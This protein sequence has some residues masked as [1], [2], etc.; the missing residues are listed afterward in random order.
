MNKEPRQSKARAVLGA[1][2]WRIPKDDWASP[3]SFENE[4][5][6]PPEDSSASLKDFKPEATSVV[7]AKHR[8]DSSSDAGLVPQ[9]T[10][11]GV[12]LHFEKD[13]PKEVIP[14]RPAAIPLPQAKTNKPSVEEDPFQL[15][16]DLPPK[17]RLPEPLKERSELPETKVATVTPLT[18]HRRQRLPRRSSDF[19]WNSLISLALGTLGL[20]LLAW[21][22]LHD[23]PRD[24]DEDLRPQVSVDQ[25]PTTQAPVKLRAFLNSVLPVEDISLRAQAPWTWE[26][27]A[28]SSFVRAN[29][30][31][32]DNLRDLL[33]DY[34][35]H[36][37]H[38]SWYL[39]DASNH[40][41]WRHA[42]CLLQAQA[43]YLARRGDEEPAFV[44]AIDL[45]EM[46]RRL[47]EVWAWSGYMQRAL[48]LQTAS[49]QILGELLKSTHL[50]SA[51][52]GRFQEEFIQC[53][54][55]DDL[56]RQA[57]AA[58][59]IHEKK[60]LLGPASGELL[61]TMPDGRLHRRPGRLFFKIN[62]TL[63]LFAS[64][65][66]NLRDEITR[67]PYTR[68]S[69]DVTSVNRI[70]L[71]TPRFYHP[72]S[73]GE[74]YFS[75]RIEPHLR[76]PEEHS[77]AQ[78]RHGLVRCLF[79]IRRFVAD[80]HKLPSQINDLT[81][82]FLTSVPMDPFSGEPFQYDT[83]RGLLY[84]VGSNLIGEGG[85]PSLLPMEDEREPTLE[86]GIKM[87]VPVKK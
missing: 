42:A 73:N 25:T 69:V 68:L 74:A 55:D 26:T 54:P 47:Q 13:E 62:E 84:S 53:R 38:S 58:Y 39:E 63:G 65:F 20:T 43:A 2:T 76:L 37:H 3:W 6:A 14:P 22:Y 23:T 61:D 78:A 79:A 64:A 21:I 29:G 30:T 40:P 80:Q 45:A 15:P 10:P 71:T 5:I 34:D 77:L 12:L 46:S 32:L 85:R 56:M 83:A 7:T 66:R 72:N 48:E 33:E 52:L 67:P 57:C 31:A 86:L 28:L 4:W 41:N 19:S 49:V 35:W 59:Y 51:T 24:S 18:P 16:L 44:A 8:G 75:N 17:R 11:H 9:I 87:A 60:L 81:P 1:M 27:P 50:D 36:P 82:K 70:R